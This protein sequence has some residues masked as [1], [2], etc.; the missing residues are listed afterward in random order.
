M[1]SVCI[2][3][4]CSPARTHILSGLVCLSAVSFSYGGDDLSEPLSF[5]I[6]SP[7]FLQ[8]VKTPILFFLLIIF[9]FFITCALITFHYRNQL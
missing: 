5:F 9:Y 6:E 3:G 2:V 8:M 7:P 1:A 4:L